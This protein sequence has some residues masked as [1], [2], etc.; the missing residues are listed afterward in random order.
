[1]MDFIVAGVL[2]VSVAYAPQS[3]TRDFGEIYTQCGLGGLIAG[4]VPV[5]AV[6]T[7]ITWDL[8]TTAI[9]SAVSSPETCRNPEARTAA[10]INEAAPKLEQDLARGQGAHLTALLELSGCPA[11]AQPA[12][13]D[14]LRVDLALR[15]SS[16]AA[17]GRTSYQQAASFHEMYTGRI[18]ADYAKVCSGG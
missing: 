3:R 8:G 10:F 18:Q 11:S 9:S 6:I 15:L 7:N 5:V 16:P 12:I 1:M 13:T 14:A 4:S 17:A 2:A